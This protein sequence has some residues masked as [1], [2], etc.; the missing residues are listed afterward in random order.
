MSFLVIKLTNY[1]IKYKKMAYIRLIMIKIKEIIKSNLKLFKKLSNLFFINFI[2]FY[3]N[4]K[5]NNMIKF[6]LFLSIIL[7]L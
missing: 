7:K 3:F 5:M 2:I 6:N 1:N 4:Y